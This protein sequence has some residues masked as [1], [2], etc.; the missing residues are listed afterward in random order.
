MAGDEL[1]SRI[2][3]DVSSSDF[4]LFMTSSKSN[5]K[6]LWENYMTYKD[7][8]YIKIPLTILYLLAR[9][10]G[11][12][13]QIKSEFLSFEKYI[14]YNLG[15][16][17][18]ESAIVIDRIKDIIG[19]VSDKDYENNNELKNKNKLIGY[20]DSIKNDGLL[21]VLE[22]AIRKLVKIIRQH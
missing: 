1:R 2:L 20:I 18:N 19:T 22:K 13:S 10:Y 7:R 5:K 14:G 6:W 8:G 4:E 12:D 21:F 9:Y 17:R 11:S 3:L 15:Q 16:H